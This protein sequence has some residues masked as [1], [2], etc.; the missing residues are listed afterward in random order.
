[1]LRSEAGESFG[2]G[3]GEFCLEG[4]CRFFLASELLRKRYCAPDLEGL[5]WAVCLKRARSSLRVSGVGVSA[6]SKR[7]RRPSGNSPSADSVE[8]RLKSCQVV[9]SLE[10]K[11]LSFSRVPVGPEER[12]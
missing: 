7:A 4:V 3:L 11:L 8:L 9:S 6:S 2:P 10:R 5:F 12:R 1:M